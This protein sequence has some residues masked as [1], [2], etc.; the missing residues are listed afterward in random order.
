VACLDVIE[1]DRDL[2]AGLS[3]RFPA[4][5]LRVHVGDALAFDLCSVGPRL[6]VVGNLPYNISSPLLFHVADCAV[7]VRDC[8]FM[9]Q[10]EVVE[11]MAAD[12]GG[13]EYGR[14]S[15]MCQY[16]FSVQKLF[17]VAAGSF[18][19]VPEVESAVVRLTPHDPMPYR[20]RSEAR[21]AQLVREAFSHRR[22]TL[23][24]ALRDQVDA[25]GFAAA[26]IDPQR[27]PETLSVEEFVRL[28]D[29]AAEAAPR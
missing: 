9:L 6:R 22:K 21:L 19:P 1:I 18:R 15:V 27:R 7:C 20:A 2:A 24:N 5:R 28:A 11:R 16:R 17:R 10:R 26:G 29:C 4:E 23:R 12:P 3:L 25:R 8:H 14:L 13:R